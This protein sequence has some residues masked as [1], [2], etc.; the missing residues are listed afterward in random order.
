MLYYP[1]CFFHAERQGR[2]KQCTRAPN[3]R[4]CRWQEF[5]GLKNSERVEKHH[6]G[7]RD[8][9]GELGSPVAGP[10]GVVGDVQG[11]PETSGMDESVTVSVTEARN[12]DGE[13]TMTTRFMDGDVEIER[14]ERPISR[15]SCT[16]LIDSVPSKDKKT[17]KNDS[18]DES[19][20]KSSRSASRSS[21]STW[22]DGGNKIDIFIKEA[23]KLIQ[24]IQKC[25]DELR[26]K[27]ERKNA[28]TQTSMRNTD[29]TENREIIVERLV[30]IAQ[31]A[32]RPPDI[33]I[34]E[35]TLS[36]S[37]RLSPSDRD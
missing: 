33:E 16:S 17:S 11:K 2:A 12:R 18:D 19:S 26:G 23:A 14:I 5:M 9:R 36:P 28:V 37:E 34:L 32:R 31:P 10:S 15:A 3:N 24:K 8:A 4:P 25:V 30:G 1:F 35:V 27:R 21:V 22:D 7:V 20:L 6:G 13:V 29:E